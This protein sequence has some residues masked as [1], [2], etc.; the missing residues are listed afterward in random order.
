MLTPCHQALVDHLRSI[1]ATGV[2]VYTLL[3]DGVRARAEGLARLVSARLH[4]RSLTGRGLCHW[5]R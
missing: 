1:V 2:D 4:Y 5:E 3:D